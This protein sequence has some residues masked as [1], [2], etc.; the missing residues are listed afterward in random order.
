MCIFGAEVQPVHTKVEMQLSAYCLL[1]HQR[2]AEWVADVQPHSFLHDDYICQ[3]SAPYRSAHLDSLS[4][5]HHA[6]CV[7]VLL[8]Q[9]PWKGKTALQMYSSS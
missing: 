1:E 4:C 6:W 9:L 5:N 7:S 3:C 2:A 8:M